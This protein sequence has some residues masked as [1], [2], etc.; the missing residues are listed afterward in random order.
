MQVAENIKQ[1]HGVA[2]VEM[3]KQGQSFE[4]PHVGGDKVLETTTDVLANIIQPR[5]E[6]IFELVNKELS[7]ARY[8]DLL[9]AG[10]VLTGGATLLPGVPEVAEAVLGV[11]A[12][13]GS[14]RGVGGLSDVVDSP[15]Y[16][17]GVG[18]VQFGFTHGGYDRAKVGREEGLYM[19]VKSRLGD[20]LGRA[21]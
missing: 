7:R 6:E 19:K 2:L 14:P 1:R 8:D 15:I 13:R 21:F 4:V 3:A 12:R 17:T 9:P 11:S 10:V 20:W 5:V 18:L 16:A